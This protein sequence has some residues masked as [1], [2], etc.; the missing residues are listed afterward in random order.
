MNSSNQPASIS[1]QALSVGWAGKAVAEKINFEIHAGQIVAI[2]GPNGAGKSTILKTIARQISSLS[3]Q[4]Y[5]DGA[6]FR[7][8]SPT[9][10]ARKVAYVAQSIDAGP[11]LTV[12]ELVSLGRNPHQHWWSWQQSGDDTAAI[13][14]AL[15][16]TGTWELRHQLLSAL[17]GG[18]R[19]RAA[20]ATALCQQAGFLL[21]D[22]PTA[23]LDFRHQIEL[24]ALLSEMKANG[25]GLLVVLHDLT[26]IAQIADKVLLLTKPENGPSVP[27]GFDSPH[28]I[29]VPD[30]LRQVYQVEVA[31]LHCPATG[32]KV[33]SATNCS[34]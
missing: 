10:F 25:L 11:N 4:I 26:F 9:C 5:V 22:E 14:Q 13:E 16:K 20:I 12:L 1:A 17:S 15:R 31:I 32:R 27:V 2:A 3:G 19:Q 7:Q 28:S 29:L 24:A 33:Y 23:H 30:T 18:E 21:L 6:D 34:K 8:I